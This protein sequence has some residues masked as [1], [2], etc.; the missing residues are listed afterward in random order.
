VSDASSLKDVLWAC[1]MDDPGEGERASEKLSVLH[2][3]LR[4][5][6][7]VRTTNSLLDAALTA[8]G[9][10]GGML[11]WSC[12]IWDIAAPWLIV[13]EAGGLYTDVA[14]DPIEF[15]LSE[16]AAQREYA[17]LAAARELHPQMRDLIADA[18]PNVTGRG[19]L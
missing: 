4:A 12:R 11:N 13:R 3:I 5:T 18:R 8:D 9:R 6:R 16:G 17:V 14:G 15:D 7:N 10:L 19:W 2:A 1:G